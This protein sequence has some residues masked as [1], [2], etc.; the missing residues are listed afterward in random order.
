M[1][2]TEKQKDKNGGQAQQHDRDALDRL[3]LAIIPLST[4]TLKNARLIKNSRMQTTVELHNDP[5]SGSLQIN[6]EDI[7]EAFSGAESDQAIIAALAALHSY[8]VYSMRSSFKKLGIP[9]GDDSLS[10][11]DSM[12]SALNNYSSEFVRPLVEKIFGSGHLDVDTTDHHAS[13]KKLLEDSDVARVKR[14]LQTITSRTGIPIDEIPAFLES[15]SDVFLSVAYYKHCF[16]SIGG[17]IQRFNLWIKELQSLRDVT[18]S[19]TSM[20]SCKKVEQSLKM[21]STSIRERLDKFQNGF[22]TFW[23]NINK[24]SFDDL[25]QQIEDNHASMGSVL[26]GLVVK[27]RNW[28]QNFPENTVGGPQ[29][30]VKFVIADMEPGL[31]NLKALENDARKQLGL[32]IL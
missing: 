30:R 26:C 1:G 10:L 3:S 18:S 5:I 6:P 19:P 8:D 32:T 24:K 16:E 20:A 27:M 21:I 4:A 31:E 22:E 2:M 29:K 15:Y 7:S 12:K 28:S 13:L 9:V 14:N 23:S 17:D 11:S 25:R